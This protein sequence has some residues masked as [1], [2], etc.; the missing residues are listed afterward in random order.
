[1]QLP[2]A[3]SPVNT[4]K[5]AKLNTEKKIIAIQ[6]PGRLQTVFV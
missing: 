1:M 2:N 3:A 4:W 6:T 5:R